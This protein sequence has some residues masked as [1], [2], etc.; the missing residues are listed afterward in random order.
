MADRWS[1]MTGTAS[2]PSPRRP[3]SASRRL[4]GRPP[5][6][7]ARP[8]PLL[9]AR[10]SSPS[11]QQAAGRQWTEREVQDAWAAG[12]WVR[13]FNAKK[14]EADGGGPQLDRLAG[15]IGDRLALAALGNE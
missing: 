3:S 12:L 14:D 1:C 2:S 15:E 11:Y 10:S 4:S 5:G 9:R 8:P 13:L 6:R 7:Q